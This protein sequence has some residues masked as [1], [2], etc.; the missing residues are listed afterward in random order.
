M[1]TNNILVTG[2]SGFIG[3]ALVAQLQ[4]QNFNVLQFNRKEGND[5]LDKEKL[6]AYSDADIQHV[7]HLAG[8]TFVPHSWEDPELFLQTNLIGTTNVLELCRH[9]NC[10]LTYISAYLY[11]LPET[12]P[13]KEDSRIYPNNPYALSKHLAEQTCQFYAENFGLTISC[14]RLFNVFGP[15]QND[16]FLIPFIIQQI[17]DSTT[18]SV[19]VKNLDPKRDYVY[20]KDVV[21]AIVKSVVSKSKKFGVYNIGSGVSLSVKEVIQTILEVANSQKT[22]SSKNEMRPNEIMD[23][24]A[25]I[26][27]AKAELDW[28]PSFSFKQGIEDMFIAKKLVS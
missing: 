9:N 16:N 20:L 26:Q 15:G 22:I 13:I 2:A 14:L 7:V 21:A 10:S 12:L 23:T 25:D 24:I 5:I 1:S 11:G 27:K 4:Q 8:A 3:Q 6:K 19:T 28:E 18:D 17:V